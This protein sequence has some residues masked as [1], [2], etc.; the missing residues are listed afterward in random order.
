MKILCMREVETEERTVS[1]MLEM[2]RSSGDVAVKDS[3]NG[4]TH[5]F[6][7]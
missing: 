6:V 7:S 4:P 2:T 3:K 1:G 5:L